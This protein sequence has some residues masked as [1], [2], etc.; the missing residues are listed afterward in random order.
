MYILQIT[1]EFPPN[2]G[3][4]GYYVYYLSRELLKM[5]QE[6]LVVLRGE[7][8]R[9]YVYGNISVK[10]IKVSDYPPFNIPMFRRKLEKILSGKKVDLIHIHSESMPALNCGC[11]VMVTAHWCMREGVANFYRPIRDVESLYKNIFLPFYTYFAKKL[12]HSCDKLTVVSYSLRREFDKYYNLKADVIYNA[13][14][15]ELFDKIEIKKEDAIL[16]VGKLCI[17]KGV[18]DLL[19]IARMLG[20]THPHVKIYIVGD[21]PLKN[22][23]YTQLCKSDLLNVKMVNSLPHSELVYYYNR[24]Q[25]FVLPSYYEGLPST[26]L[27]AMACKLPVVATNVSGIPELIDEGVTGYML[28]PGDI[29]GFYNRIVELL[30][31]S[32]KQKYFGEMGRKK[33]IEKF[34]WPHITQG[35]I[36]KYQELLEMQ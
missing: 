11:P 18:L 16:F 10:E 5:G 23:I 27:E 1:P 35:I 2:C 20:K 31:N 34:T 22:Y 26:I 36:N 7:E 3:G 25:I 28:P 32:E 15:T 21:G 12:V 9:D 29:N 14:D 4:I 6:V 8:N 19:D 33:V 17:G 24:S 30:E 13:V